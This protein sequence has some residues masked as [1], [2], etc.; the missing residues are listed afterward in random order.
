MAD[1]RRQ[2][3]VSASHRT[4]R[5]GE[6]TRERTR[7][8]LLGEDLMANLPGTNGSDAITARPEIA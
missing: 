3:R 4:V 1:T 2:P 7:F 5:T 6:I 8:A